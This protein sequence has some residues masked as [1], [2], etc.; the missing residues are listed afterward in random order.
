[1][2]HRHDRTDAKGLEPLAS[3]FPF[4]K[5]RRV[6]DV[7]GATATSAREHDTCVVVAGRVTGLS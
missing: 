7:I 6:V 1:M 2:R 4:A 3:F 5:R